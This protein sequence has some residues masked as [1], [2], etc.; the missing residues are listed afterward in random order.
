[1]N[2]IIYFVS[3]TATLF[4][5]CIQYSYAGGTFDSV[6]EMNDNEFIES[7]SNYSTITNSDIKFQSKDFLVR[8]QL[9][10][11]SADESKRLKL[12]EENSGIGT[13]LGSKKFRL[14]FLT[15]PT[16]T[17]PAEMKARF[18]IF[19][20]GRPVYR[21][22]FKNFRELDADWIDEKALKVVSWPGT[23]VRII[24]LIN[25]ETGKIIYKSA[26][27][28]YDSLEPLQPQNKN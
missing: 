10:W 12:P 26:S 27:G 1:M 15:D 16:K 17:P 6:E 24:E 3:V 19:Q 22:D 18:I 20:E 4:I 5:C 28:I 14:M 13:P 7:Y 2:C 23:R 25:V 11:I 21:F 8:S 9:G